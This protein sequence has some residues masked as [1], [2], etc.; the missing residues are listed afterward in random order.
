M[1]KLKLHAGSFCSINDSDSIDD[2]GLELD[3]KK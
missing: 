2:G 3:W 1:T